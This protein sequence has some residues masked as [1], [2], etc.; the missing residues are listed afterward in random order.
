VTSIQPEL[1]ID[2]AA[3]AVEF[4]QAAF[5]AEV[6]HRVGQGD[7]IVAQLAIGGAAFWVSSG[8]SD[9]PRFS[10][11][12][13]GGA[14]GRILLVA[15]DPDAMFGRAVA[16]GASPAGEMAEE[17]GWRLGRIIDPFGHEWEIGRP[18]GAWPPA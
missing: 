11:R 1:W 13:I 7:D 2:R 14:T 17:H 4:Y 10:P 3:A 16:A 8:G 6:Q 5:G 18:L 15:D 12:A 9:G